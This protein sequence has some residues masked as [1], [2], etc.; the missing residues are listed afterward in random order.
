MG[1]LMA[2]LDRNMR[3]KIPRRKTLSCVFQEI[4]PEGVH[5]KR[6]F[7]EQEHIGCRSELKIKVDKA[8]DGL[9]PLATDQKDSDTSEAQSRQRSNQ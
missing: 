1:T 6:S 3:G 5:C 2:T 4:L 7:R 9:C 8:T